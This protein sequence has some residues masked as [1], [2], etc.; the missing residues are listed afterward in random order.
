MR[1][2][3]AIAQLG[4]RCNRTAEV[5]SSNLIGSTK[6][7]NKNSDIENGDNEGKIA[8]NYIATSRWHSLALFATAK[9]RDAL[10]LW[11]SGSPSE[12]TRRAYKRE[13]EAFV[14]FAGWDDVAGAVAH[15]LGLESGQATATVEAWR[16][17]KLR[18]GLSAASINR[19]ISAVKSFVTSARRFGLTT[20]QLD[21]KGMRS[22][23]YRDTKGPGV[24]GVQKMLIA[25]NAGTP[26]KAARDIAIIRLAYSLGLRRGEIASLNIGHL[27]LSAGTLSV[28]GKGRTEREPMTMPANAK[29]ALSNWLEL[30]GSNAAEAPLFISLDNASKGKRISG[31]G[32][33]HLIRDQLG[34]RAN[35]PARPHGIRHTAITAA[36][37]H[38]GGDYRLVRSFSRHAS[39]QTIAR[40]DD[41]RCDNAGKVAKALD[42]ILDLA[43]A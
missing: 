19:S 16:A 7:Y 43:A 8:S 15:F 40:Y 3:G 4:E 39:L 27:D 22:K 18:D 12:N 28:L 26:E 21:V 29:G 33:Y 34:V 42:S 20:L 31:S 36:L 17:K 35:V 25:A 38:T 24:K 23:A 5:V 30:R 9:T 14:A 10:D 13:I 1:A 2:L 37:D 6:N 41:N 32:I 11:L